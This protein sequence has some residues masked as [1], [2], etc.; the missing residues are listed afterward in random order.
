MR[1]E[2]STKV[3]LR[4]DSGTA[5]QRTL[6]GS[7][8]VGQK[9]PCLKNYIISLAQASSLVSIAHAGQP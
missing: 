8:V 2:V 5:V 3:E 9:F 4:L 7:V 1:D 6:A